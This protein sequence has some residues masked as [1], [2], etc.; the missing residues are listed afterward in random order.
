MQRARRAAGQWCAR[1]AAGGLVCG[2]GLDRGGRFVCSCLTGDVAGAAA[3]REATAH[4][5][6][7]RRGEGEVRRAGDSRSV[8]ATRVSDAGGNADGGWADGCDGA[9]LRK[10]RLE[11]L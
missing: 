10:R 11:S 9:E 1:E 7:S 5:T 4:A 6:A 8:S 3:N 2:V